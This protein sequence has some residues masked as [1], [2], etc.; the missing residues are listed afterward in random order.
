M[1]DEGNALSYPSVSNVLARL[2]ERAEVI[3]GVR[4]R[5]NTRLAG[6]SHCNR[7]ARVSKT[8]GWEE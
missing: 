8:P 3:V 5:K 2:R 7:A 4:R 6:S 1:L